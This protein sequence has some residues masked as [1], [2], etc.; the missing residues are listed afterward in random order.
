MKTR[1]I[2]KNATR[3]AWRGKGRNALLIILTMT[4]TAGST[5]GLS[6]RNAAQASMDAALVDTSITATIGVDR[7]KI[8]QKA[9]SDNTSDNNDDKRADMREALSNSALTLADYKRYGITSISGSKVNSWYYETAGATKTNDFQPVESSTSMTSSTTDNSASSS[10]DKQGSSENRQPDRPDASG[11][12]AVNGPGDGWTRST[13]DFQLIGFSSDEALENGPN[14]AFTLKSGKMPTYDSTDDG[15]VLVSKTLADF[16]GLKT[17]DKITVKVAKTSQSS[18]SSSSSMEYEEKTLTIA[19]VYEN[20]TD[21]SST[22]APSGPMGGSSQDSANAIYT[23]VSTLKSLGLAPA[24][25]GSDSDS[26]PAKDTS[27]TYT[28][29]LKDLD[30]YEKFKAAVDEKLE[31]GYVVQSRDVDS[32]EA[33]VTPLKNI[34]KFATTLTI[35]VVSVGAATIVMVSLLAMRDRKYEIGVLTAIGIRK[36]AVAFQ[37]IVESM[38]VV[39]IGVA[40][41]LGIGA[42]TSQPIASS[43]LESQQ[44]ASQSQ[45]ASQREMFG[46]DMQAPGSNWNRP[47]GTENNGD[48]ADTKTSLDAVT[49]SPTTIAE[50]TGIGVLL[51]VMSSMIGVLFILRYDP[52]RILAER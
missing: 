34:S 47:D 38:V 30:A 15:K 20:K 2:I 14:G 43:L 52:L 4:I 12:S 29:S 42:A 28:Y 23:T 8:M 32:Y 39:M 26:S 33:S 44:S 11:P 16:N 22:Q 48:T 17:G 21:D 6:I 49:V 31:D 24:E 35:I 5:I 45:E 27:I 51:A 19:G 40:L 3:D 37:F 18:V 13:G 25:D 36:G 46:R 50:V 1:H 41:G 9:S 7:S 10:S